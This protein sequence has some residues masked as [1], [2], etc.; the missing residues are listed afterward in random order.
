[1]LYEVITKIPDSLSHFTSIEIP[2]KKLIVT[3]TTHIPSLEML[4][5]ENKLAAFPT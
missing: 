2:V 3:S 5:E 1:M 4:G